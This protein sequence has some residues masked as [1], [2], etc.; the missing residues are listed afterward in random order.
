MKPNR[1]HRRTGSLL[2]SALLFWGLVS[3]VTH[4]ATSYLQ[5]LEAEAAATDEEASGSEAAS[6]PNWS[7]QEPASGGESLDKGMSKTQFDEALK[8]RYYG[9]YLFYSTLTDKKQQAVYEEYQKKQR[10]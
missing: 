3:P 2:A 5:E 9:S 7:S 8:S 4:A 6:T 1:Y 10:D